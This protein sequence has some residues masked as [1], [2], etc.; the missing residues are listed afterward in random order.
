MVHK[1]IC[2]KCKEEKIVALDFYPRD[3]TCKKCRKDRQKVTKKL[4]MSG[5]GIRENKNDR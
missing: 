3:L 5:L 4:R 2:D 1:L